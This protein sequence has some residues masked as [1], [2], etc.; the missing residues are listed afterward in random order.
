ML[1]WPMIHINQGFNRGLI[2]AKTIS[3]ES[4]NL[5][6]VIPKKLSIVLCMISGEGA[7]DHVLL[8]SIGTT[9][10]NRDEERL[11]RDVQGRD[12]PAWND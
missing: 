3:Y 4:L 12:Q 2:R 7:I 10:S 1:S 9:V 11:E 5:R 8:S 6:S